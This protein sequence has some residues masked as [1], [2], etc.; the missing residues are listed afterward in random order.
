MVGVVCYDPVTDTHEVFVDQM[1]ELTDTAQVKLLARWIT[2]MHGMV[3]LVPP[4]VSDVAT[5]PWTPPPL[6]HWSSAE[7]SFLNTLFR[8]KPHLLDDL[9]QECPLAYTVLS[10]PPRPSPLSRS[11]STS[12]SS[13]SPTA[14]TS[15]GLL[16]ADLS[17][18]FI[19]E[20]IAIPGC[21]DYQLKHVV[22]AL[23]RLGA[24]PSTYVWDTNGV[25]DGLSAM[26]QAEEAYAAGA[27]SEESGW[28]AQLEE[29]RRYNEADVM[30]LV[31]VVRGVLKGMV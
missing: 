18:V 17:Q 8:R 23:V 11:A 2:R 20:P 14:S 28:N 6:L 21:F 19:H 16:W 24:M 29:I 22:R 26:R 27:Y 30:V 5:P 4:D 13:S 15:L 3:P 1:E 12:S 25:Q 7:P 9:Q 10:A 31:D